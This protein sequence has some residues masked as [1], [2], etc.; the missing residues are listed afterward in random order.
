MQYWIAAFAVAIVVVVGYAAGPLGAVITVLAF[1]IALFLL[2][3]RELGFKGAWIRFGL[4]RLSPPLWKRENWEQFEGIF[5][6]RDKVVKA[7]AIAVSLIALSMMLPR[8]L[9]VIAFLAIA[10]WAVVEIYRAN[11]SVARAT[12]SNLDPF[13]GRAGPTRTDGPRI[14]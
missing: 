3:A 5:A 1:L 7:G 14:N 6:D 8:N 11:G 12:G 13:T 10:V 9:V 4:N 2:W